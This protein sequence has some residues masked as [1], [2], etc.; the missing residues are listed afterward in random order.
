MTK[1]V[2]EDWTMLMRFAKLLPKITHNVNRVV[3]IF[4]EPVSQ[5]VHEITPTYLTPNVLQTLRQADYVA[6]GTLARHGMTKRLSQMPV[7]IVPIHFNCDSRQTPCQRSIVV[8]T[9]IT[10][11]FMTGVP[12]Q[13]NKHIPLRVIQEMVEQ[14]ERVNG[15]SR[16]L[17]DLTP[18]PPGTTEWE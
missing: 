6:Q 16:V 1:Q 14:I 12:A 7:I 17:Y 4:G 5:P 3:F 2:P 15:V 9:F 13:P 18:K 10:E 11:D 8:R